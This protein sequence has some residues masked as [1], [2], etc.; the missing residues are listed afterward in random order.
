MKYKE[1]SDLENK[2]LD[3]SQK[4]E[5]RALTTAQRRANMRFYS[6][7]EP[8]YD[9]ESNYC[10]DLSLDSILRTDYDYLD[11]VQQDIAQMLTMSHTF[12]E[13]AD[14]YNKD[15]S[16]VSREIGKIQELVSTNHN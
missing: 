1:L 12:D 11:D 8:L 9:C 5:L 4:K 15:K 13:I 16:W 3:D 14:K 7:C 2:L 10:T 6:R